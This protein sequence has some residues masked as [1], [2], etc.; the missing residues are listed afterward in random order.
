MTVH[1]IEGN[2]ISILDDWR[3]A[4]AINN[5]P[6]EDAKTFKENLSFATTDMEL[7]GQPEN[8]MGLS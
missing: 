7:L 5:E 8:F 2:H 3:I 1:K 6:L 4:A